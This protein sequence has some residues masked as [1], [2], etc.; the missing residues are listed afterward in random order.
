V[1][2]ED[3]GEGFLLNSLYAG[4]VHDAKDLRGLGL[5]GM[6]ERVFLIKGTMD[7]CSMPGVGTRIEIKI[8]LATL[9]VDEHA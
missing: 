7:L 1:E 2:I 5:L 9:E 6:K 3:D 4:G 8:P